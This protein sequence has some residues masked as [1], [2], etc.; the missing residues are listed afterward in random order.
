VDKTEL[1]K[2]GEIRETKH[3]IQVYDKSLKKAL[4]MKRCVHLE[5]ASKQYDGLS[6]KTFTPEE[7]KKRHMGKI[8]CIVKYTNDSELAKILQIYFS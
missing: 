2:F 4:V 5:D 7:I 3:Y 1:S 6:V 8:K